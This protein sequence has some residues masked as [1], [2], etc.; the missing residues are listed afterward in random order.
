MIHFSF[1]AAPTLENDFLDDLESRIEAQE[2]I[3]LESLEELAVLLK[4][5]GVKI[6][7]SDSLEVKDALNCWMLNDSLSELTQE[8]FDDFYEHWLKVTNR[9][10]N[11]DEYGQLICFNSFI[12]RLNQA[13][14]K[15]VLQ[16]AI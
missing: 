6:Q 5:Y 14:Y 7:H 3:S 13:K 4:T 2:T 8:E 12:G 1:V 15:V 9:D 16:E 11:M 10:N